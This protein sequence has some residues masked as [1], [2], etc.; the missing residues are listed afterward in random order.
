MSE[1]QE[2]V[3]IPSAPTVLDEFPTD[4]STV[5]SALISMSE[6]GKG[7]DATPVQNP[8]T[9]AVALEQATQGALTYKDALT[10]LMSDGGYSSKTIREHAAAL[11]AKDVQEMKLDFNASASAG[12]VMQAEN[13][14]Q[15]IDLYARAAQEV[16]K[17]KALSKIMKEAA[18]NVATSNPSTIENNSSALIFTVTEQVGTTASITELA[19]QYL[20]KRK[21]APSQ[22]AF[23]GTLGVAI[24]GPLA[25]GMVNPVAGLLAGVSVGSKFSY[26]SFVT[27]PDALEQVGGVPKKALSYAEQINTWRNNLSKMN[28]Q[29]ALNNIVG[30]FDYISSKEVLPGEAGKVFTALNILRL[31]DKFDE[32]EW[33]KLSLSLTTQEFLDRV[34]LGFDAAGVLSLVRRAAMPVKAASELTGGNVAG[35]VVA[36]DI[37]NNTNKAGVD[38]ADQ[39]GYSL[40]MD[41]KKY[42]PDGVVGTSATVQRSLEETLKATIQRLEERVK[43]T[44]DVEAETMRDFLVKNSSK[45]NSA[46]VSANLENGEVVLQHLS[47]APYRSKENAL[48]LATKMEAE[49]GLKWEVV[50]AN[51]AATVKAARFDFNANKVD[52]VDTSVAM[53]LEEARTGMFDYFGPGRLTAKS[54][55]EVVST[56]KEANAADKALAKV[57]SKMPSLENVKVETFDN[58]ID[59]AKK[60]PHLKA[61]DEFKAFQGKYEWRTNTIYLQRD[62]AASR[63]L[64]LH[65]TLHAA[66]SQMIDVVRSGNKKL[67]KAAN[68]SPRQM[69]AISNLR[70]IYKDVQFQLNRGIDTGDFALTDATM[71]GMK[72]V[73]EMISE[74]LTNPAF[75]DLLRKITL[76]DDT[77]DMLR[78]TDEGWLGKAKSVWDVFTRA[79]AKALGLPL[80]NS[81][82]LSRFIEENARLLKSVDVEQQAL[83]GAMERAGLSAEKMVA[84]FDT[85]MKAAT[86]LAHGWYVR[87]AG[88]NMVHTTTDIESR[89]GAG[90]DPIHRASELAVHDR[91]LA[92]MQ[93]MKDR[94]A[95]SK[96]LDEGFK[97]LSRKQH[98]RVVKTLEE[99]DTIGKDFN[100]IEL[101]ARGLKSD[102]EQKAYYAYRTLS[103]L[104]LSIKNNT[105]KENLTRRGFFQGYIKDGLVTHFAP[106]KNISAVD[107]VGRNAYNLLTG[108]VERIDSTTMA[109]RTLVET[110]KPITIGGQEYT[111]LIGDNSN[112]SFGRLRD[113]IPN[114]PGTF[115]RYY[116]QDYFGDVTTTRVVN[117]EQ[118]EDVLH[119]RT[120]NS[121]RDIAKWQD[122]MNAIL[123]QHRGAPGSVTRAFI[124]R[125]LGRFE[126]SASIYQSI[127]KGEWDNYVKFGNHYDRANDTYIDTLAKAQW[128]DDLAKSDARGMRLMSIDADKNNILDPVQAVTAELTNVARHRNVDSWRDK[129][130]ATW[131]N[132]FSDSL[133][134]SLV[135]SGRSPLAIMS[136]PSIQLSTY[137]R[138]DNAGKFADSQR[139]YILAQLGVKTLDEQLLEGALKR[140]TSS[141]SGDAKVLGFPIGESVITAGHALRNA[142][143]L[144]F[145]RSF[146]FFTMLAAF[147]PAQL[148]VQAAGAV[149][150]IA[151]S[152][153]HGMKAAYT[154]PLLRMALASDNPAVW[155]KVATLEEWA[156]LGFGNKQDFVDTVRAVRKL[157]IMD[158][159]VATSMH[160]AEAGRYNML[161]GFVSKMGEKSAMFFNR[162]EEFARLTAFEVA[163]REWIATNPNMPWNTDAVLKGLLTRMD[164]L[165]Q[166]MTRSNLAFYQRGV[167]SIPGQFLQYNIKLAAN[168]T[169]AMYSWAANKPYRGYSAKEASSILATHTVLYGLA[170]NGLM[171]VYDEVVGGYEQVVGRQ[172]TDDEKLTMSQ[173]LMAGIINELS[174]ATSGED[175]KLAVGSRLGVFEYYDKMAKTIMKGDASF[176]EV[177]LGPSYGSVTRMGGMEALVQPFIRKDLTMDAFGEAL[178]AVGKETFSGW[179]N[180]SVAYYAALHDGGVVD[181]EGTSQ[182]T[183]TKGEIVAQALGMHASVKEDFW[184][185]N[186]SLSER[187]QAVKDYAK[188]YMDTE[189]VSL[190]VLKNEGD[191]KRYRTLTDYMTTLHSKLP[192]GEREY[193]W[194]LI[195]KPT[196]PAATAPFIDKQTKIRADYLEGSWTLKDVATTRSRALTESKPLESK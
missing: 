121:G 48:S 72:D 70:D 132:T 80:D 85:N 180:G 62:L 187:R 43:I 68:I 79:M 102:K 136:D 126:D 32:D 51:D 176:W 184:R 150:A 69:A 91:T 186:L 46:V 163:R 137:T 61:T 17:E 10:N 160:S 113:Q 4:T 82:A 135:K 128:D 192:A 112:I 153:I 189:K 178:T 86:P 149:N 34:G 145:I 57:L 40:S 107:N 196:G 45:Y 76:S 93:E 154:A 65:E 98:A 83:V 100:V 169:G 155:N 118:V 142:D 16:D 108:K 105:L 127:I 146:N 120:S 164:D 183:L 159:I 52:D 75:Q 110:G 27:I 195:T 109:G 168:I 60:L 77:M 7:T 161:T 54:V 8:N 5:D 131:W 167:L 21:L 92:L 71:Y 9:M 29:D 179:K 23:L 50:P 47:G 63:S 177:V 139:R 97:G 1:P 20:A 133:P 74:G 78:A 144:Q 104:D 122:G 38:S 22:A 188:T 129:W 162:G 2:Q 6:G 53:L 36:D 35:K 39:V 58:A 125:Q 49:T 157:G 111:R 134:D 41:L 12:M 114:K 119:L 15:S 14:A 147:N 24:A 173:G 174:Q 44:G 103:N 143:P 166:N 33:R 94:A 193:F 116:T 81:N 28:P 96:F 89:F 191:S 13:I 194:Q 73:H 84:M 124:E 31:S 101:G 117:G 95:L 37:L 99:G 151:V 148:F 11:Y 171:S 130:V 123:K 42:L 172:V 140:F 182:F 165:T 106:T 156:K 25:A 90:L 138:G 30:V 88:T 59:L 66:V 19:D 170:G 115:R 26:D 18:V 190:E 64:V 56:S 67:I 55:M 158:G 3:I 181:K 87:H 185:V 141:F 175:L 152:P